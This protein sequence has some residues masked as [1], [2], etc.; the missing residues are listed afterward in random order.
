MRFLVALRAKVPSFGEMVQGR[1]QQQ[2]AEECIR[3]MLAGFAAALPMKNQS[4]EDTNSVDEL[5]G[6][7]TK[8]VYKCVECDD[9]PEQED[10]T[11]DR[12]LFCH[13]GTTTE[14]ISHMREGIKMSLKEHVEKNSVTLGRSAQYTKT[15]SL[16]SL[17]KYLL[18][19]FARFG[20]KAANS[21]AGTTAS[22][23]KIGRKVQFPKRLD[24]FEFT[25]E[26]LQK[27]LQV[28][29]QKV[30]EQRDRDWEAAQQALKVG[31]NLD[32]QMAGEGEE[33]RFVD[34]G[35]FE[36]VAVVSHQGRTAE[37]GHYVGW[38]ISEKADGK[39]KKDDTWLLFDDE[40]VSE[41]LDKDVDLA[42]GRLDTHIAYFCLYKKAATRIV[43]KIGGEGHVLGSAEASSSGAAGG[44]AGDAP[45]A[46]A[47]AAD[48]KPMDVDGGAS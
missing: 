24:A 6:F 33:E 12:F 1:P 48:S 25:A 34:T 5:F 18:V 27:D 17:P 32:I 46:G 14:P 43:E 37:G 40:N 10:L 13:F 31:T 36:L 35:A 7:K 9:E 20:W 4:G 29:R 38:A 45:A 16:Q 47:G 26:G 2:D 19:Q 22:R 15:A 21:E 11:M 42:G 39:K 44:G 3:N 8:S 28:A 30:S 41:R 23:V